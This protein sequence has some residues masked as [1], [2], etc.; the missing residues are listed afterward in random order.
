MKRFLTVILTL[1]ISLHLLAQSKKEIKADQLVANGSYYSAIQEYQKE[2]GK[3]K[4][5]ISKSRLNYKIG[6]TY[7]MLIPEN[8]SANSNSNLDLCHQAQTFYK[9]ANKLKYWG[10]KDPK[11]NNI[12]AGQLYLRH[13]L[14]KSAILE[15]EAYLKWSEL[16]HNTQLAKEITNAKNGLRSAQ[17]AENEYLD[18]HLVFTLHVA[19][20][21][22]ETGLPL[23]GVMLDTINQS[24]AGKVFFAGQGT[25]KDWSMKREHLSPA[26]TT[27]WDQLPRVK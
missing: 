23:K 9:R 2:E 5:P 16:D 7:E 25:K 27:R 18:N 6:T 8:S 22:K 24:G 14:F 13:N 26:Y 11:Y 20:L 19:V 17:K 15:F 21:N 12:I 3:Q 10:N 1:F 4:T